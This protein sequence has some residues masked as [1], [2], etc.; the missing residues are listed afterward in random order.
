ME[1]IKYHIK[2]GKEWAKR[3]Y[4][5]NKPLNVQI[6]WQLFLLITE[7]VENENN[8]AGFH[9]GYTEIIML[10]MVKENPELIML[11]YLKTPNWF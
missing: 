1:E 4:W 8:K 9:S 10:T 6:S 3:D 2:I 11:P 7:T 5:G